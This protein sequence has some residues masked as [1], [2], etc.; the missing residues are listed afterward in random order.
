MNK[1]KRKI[2]ELLTYAAEGDLSQVKRLCESE[3]VDVN[4]ADYDHRTALHVAAAEGHGDVV[5]YLLAH[6][7][8][9]NAKDRWGKTPLMD[10][11]TFQRD[12]IALILKGSGAALAS[13][14][15]ANVVA[16]LCAAAMRN[17]V[18]EVK[19]VALGG[20][21]V[22]LSD[23]D[24]RT[25]LHVASSEGHLDMCKLLLLLGADPQCKDRWGSTPLAE[26]E[27]GHHIEVANFLRFYTTA[28]PAVTKRRR[29]FP[30]H[31]GQ[32]TTLARA[33]SG[34]AVVVSRSSGSLGGELSSSRS[35][36]S[37]DDDDDDDDDESESVTE[38]SENSFSPRYSGGSASASTSPANSAG[39]DALL[40]RAKGVRKS[41][42]TTAAATSS[43][44]L[45]P[46]ERSAEQPRTPRSARSSSSSSSSK[47]KSSS[48]RRR[49][50][51]SSRRRRRRE[52]E[53]RRSSS[54]SS[55]REDHAAALLAAGAEQQDAETTQPPPPLVDP[56]DLDLSEMSEHEEIGCGSFGSVCKARYRG[57]VV[58]IKTMKT[59]SGV[60]DAAADVVVKQ[61]RREMAALMRLQ[62]RNVVKLIGVSIKPPT[63]AIVTEFVDGC[64]LLQHL[65]RFKAADPSRAQIVEQ[66][67]DFASQMAEGMRHAHN[68]GII[69]R[70]LKSYVF[71]F[72]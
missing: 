55:L 16:N 14:N 39:G 71:F 19:R 18:N 60:T 30:K 48:G 59:S 38:S 22:N 11:L 53:Q 4:G 21:D 9:M 27:N 69:H 34:S 72:S 13:Q 23:Y 50:K 54:S 43:L 70:D 47:R 24:R 28:S 44:S 3:G 40:K 6:G 26:A 62:H 41:V 1:D 57:Q 52:R 51:H 37:D 29:Y 5:T 49:S 31:A 66:C 45:T 12:D 64:N 8:D 32:P 61:L 58:A 68:N 67:I 46:P 15:S 10:A 7:T 63:I 36:E 65:E 42:S 2:L 56:F 25:P 17:D 33:E 20:V 35:S